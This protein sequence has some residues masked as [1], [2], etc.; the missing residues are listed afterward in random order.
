MKFCENNQ[1]SLIN[2][3]FK[4]TPEYDSNDRKN[5]E[6]SDRLYYDGSVF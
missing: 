2:T 5:C 3:N 1:M 6:K 4:Y